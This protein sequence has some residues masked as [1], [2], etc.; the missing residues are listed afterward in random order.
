MKTTFK[1]TALLILVIIL[2]AGKT[3]IAEEKTKK[4]HESWS[5][6][7]VETLDIS[8]K[9]GEVKFKNEGGT[10]ITIDVLVTVEASSESKANDLLEMID[11]DFSKS[12]STVKAVTTIENNFKSQRKFSINYEINVPSDKNL[13]VSNKY[14]N[15][16]VN[17]LNANGDF[18]I[19]YGNITAN[20]L[21]A[22]ANGKMN[23][24]L[25]YGNGNVETTG[26]LNLDIKYSNISFGTINDFILESKYSTVE[27]DKGHIIQIDSKYDKLN[28]GRVKSVSAITKYSQMK[29]EF[30]AS[31]LKIETGY[32][33]VKVNEVAPDFESVSITNSYGQISLGLNNASYSVDA[34]CDYCGISYPQERFKGNRMKENNSYEINGKIG[35]AGGGTVMIRSRY[36]EIKL[37][38]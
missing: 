14:G 29:I 15:T 1:I 12:G 7:G 38:E 2:G 25:A 13:V 27:F 9:F 32:G 30:L 23:I 19:Q 5:A 4:Y 10:E 31:N 17:K 16:I 24:M 22:P 21:V 8:N 6:A 18:D 35:T 3:V 36:G 33:G 37:N 26:N 11:V 20:E 28:F 34:K